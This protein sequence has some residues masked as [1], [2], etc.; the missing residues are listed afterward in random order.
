MPLT[1]PKRRPLR[2]AFTKPGTW[3]GA[4]VAVAALGALAAAVA[5]GHLP[6]DRALSVAMTLIGG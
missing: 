3:P 2:R 6:L 1:A 4:I 5:S